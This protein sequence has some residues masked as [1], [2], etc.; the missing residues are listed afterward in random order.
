MTNPE[1]RKLATL[2]LDDENG[3]NEE[4]YNELSAHLSKEAVN[5]D[6]TNAVEAMEGRFFLNEDHGIVA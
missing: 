3:I 6:I 4:A 5:E 1:L 2:L